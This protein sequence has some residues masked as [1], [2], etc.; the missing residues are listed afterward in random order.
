METFIEALIFKEKKGGNM[1]GLIVVGGVDE[2]YARN[3]KYNR[4]EK[5]YATVSW[6]ITDIGLEAVYHGLNLSASEL[7]RILEDNESVIKEAMLQAGWLAID[8]IMS[9]E[10]RRSE[11]EA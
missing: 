7:E 4:E 1:N 2:D 5:A 10:K 6:T 3:C 8:V 11:D 9:E